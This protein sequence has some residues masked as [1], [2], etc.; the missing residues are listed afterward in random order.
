[1]WF[2]DPTYGILADYEGYKADPEQP[3]RNVYRLDPKTGEIDAVVT[4]FHQPNGL[5]FRRTK[6]GSMS[7]T[8]PIA[9]TRTHRAIS[10]SSTLWMVAS[11]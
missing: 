3:S 8:A 10:A 6:P 11:A 7:P 1:M 4:D 2:T 5:A 9:T